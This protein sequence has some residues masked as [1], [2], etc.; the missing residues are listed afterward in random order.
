MLLSYG[1]K[2]KQYRVSKDIT[3]EQF[4]EQLTIS[5]SM[6]RMIE[7]GKRKPNK[8]VQKEIYNLTGILYN[9]EIKN[10]ITNKVSEIIT[11]YI[12]SQSNFFTTKNITN[13]IRLL[14]ETTVI[15]H[16]KNGTMVVTPQVENET[17]EQKYM[18]F[19]IIEILN[20]FVEN[21]EYDIS[22]L[23][24]SNIEF[25]KY[26]LPT[27]IEI[28]SKSGS[29]IHKNKEIPLYTEELP[30]EIKKKTVKNLLP[31]NYFMECSKFAYVIQD[32][33]MFPKY[34][35]GYT[36]IAIECDEKN[37]TGDVIVSINGNSPILRKIS[38]QDNIVILES[39]NQ[40]V[41]TE[42]YTKNDIK[43]LG[44]IVAIRLY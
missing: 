1:E 5:V 36:V 29:I 38:Y 34:E 33:T 27:I 20:K 35:K 24:G 8:E 17:E 12:A 42:I 3:Q 6:L 7:I 40:E 19:N 44:K 18:V 25:V 21:S 4:A 10:E 28:I 32:N 30:I 26:Y 15:T 16:P 41:K 31:E 14:S 2:I 43:I 22:S 23:Y 9:D 11:N 13:L 37:T 39:Y